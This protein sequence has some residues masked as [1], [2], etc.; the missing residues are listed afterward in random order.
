[1]S[2]F[3]IDINEQDIIN[4][5]EIVDIYKNA[6]EDKTYPFVLT[7]KNGR[8]FRM[9]EDCMYRLIAFIKR[10][11]KRKIEDRN[12]RIRLTKAIISE[13]ENK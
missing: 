3:F 1:M 2:T 6:S 9:K 8:V 12:L 11:E 5:D 13:K 7:F 4:V 10:Y